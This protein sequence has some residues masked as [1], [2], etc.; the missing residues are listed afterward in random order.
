MERDPP[1]EVLFSRRNPRV[2][3]IHPATAPKVK[4]VRM[5]R[6]DVSGLTSGTRRA[7]CP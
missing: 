2:P 3:E 6:D 1:I 4:T 7:G 5:I